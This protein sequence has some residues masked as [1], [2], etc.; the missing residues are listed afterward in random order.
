[1]A[2][3]IFGENYG[4]YTLT[5]L[6]AEQVINDQFVPAPNESELMYMFSFPPNNDLYWSL[7]V[8]PGK[9]C[10]YFIYVHTNLHVGK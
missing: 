7:P 4:G 9:Y 5:D 8:F 6:N 10:V 1:M 2:A 3:S